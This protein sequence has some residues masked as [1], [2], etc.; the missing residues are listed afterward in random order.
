MKG[1]RPRGWAL[2]K[3]VTPH[4]DFVRSVGNEGHYLSSAEN[5]A[6]FQAGTADTLPFV[7]WANGARRRL[8]CCYIGW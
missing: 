2:G 6:K 1:P 8:F 4:L 3:K 5:Q 7:G